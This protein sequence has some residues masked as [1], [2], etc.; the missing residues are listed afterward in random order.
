M[1]P[2][3]TF[4]AAL[5]LFFRHASPLILT[6][7][8]VAAVAWRI[9]LGAWSIW[10]AGIALGWFL[11]WPF[12]EWLIHVHILHFR[13]RTVLGIRIDPANSRKH[14][15]HHLEP[16]EIPLTFIPLHT[17]ATSLPLLLGANLLVL[18]TL[19]LA[20]TSIAVFVVLSLHYEWCHYLAHI[21]WTPPIA[22]Y[23]RICK[24]HNLHHHRHEQRWF[25]VSRTFADTV[26][27]TSPD[28][29]STPLSPT[30][31]TLGIP[32]Q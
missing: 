18:P 9:T 15:R 10:D 4:T 5:S 30:V 13:P 25:G 7:A 6:A 1:T 11:F 14:R 16:N 29:A 32:P 27:G 22:Y 20:V 24:A 8:S 2:P 19:P 28:V 12:Q 31:R 23:R 3:R 21:P 26:L 17:F